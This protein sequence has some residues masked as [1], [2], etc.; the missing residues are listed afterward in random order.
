[1]CVCGCVVEVVVVV[2]MNVSISRLLYYTDIK[3]YRYDISACSIHLYQHVAFTHLSI[4]LNSFCNDGNSDGKS[5]A[6]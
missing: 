1:M 6:I 5:L 3:V 2:L 4:L